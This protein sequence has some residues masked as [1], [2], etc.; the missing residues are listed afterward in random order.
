MDDYTQFP[1]ELYTINEI[2]QMMIKS[3][4]I[5]DKEFV[6]ACREAIKRRK[7]EEANNVTFQQNQDTPH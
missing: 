5:D 6:A 3:I 4:A 7:P 2:A 1:F